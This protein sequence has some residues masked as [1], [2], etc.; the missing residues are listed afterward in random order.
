MANPSVTLR[1]C[2][3]TREC[4][5]MQSSPFSVAKNGCWG[6]PCPGKIR[7]QR[8]QP[9]WENSWAVRISPRNS[10][11]G[12]VIDSEKSSIAANR[13]STMGFPMGHQPQSCVNIPKMAF[14]YP[15]LAFFCMKTIFLSTVCKYYFPL[16]RF[17]VNTLPS[18]A[19]KP[20]VRHNFRGSC[21]PR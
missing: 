17:C 20:A 7:V 9:P 16:S 12:A 3:K 14:R 11:S 5:G 6:W 8:G 10:G 2:V 13:K 15:N 18:T 21:F 19:N 1:Y 4:R